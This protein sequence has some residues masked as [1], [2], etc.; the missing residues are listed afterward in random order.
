[1]HGVQSVA[2]LSL[3]YPLVIT[4]PMGD[5]CTHELGS[6]GDS[7]VLYHVTAHFL[8]ITHCSITLLTHCLVAEIQ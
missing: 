8:Q 2:G 6:G 7:V 1:M 5:C 4:I 3:G